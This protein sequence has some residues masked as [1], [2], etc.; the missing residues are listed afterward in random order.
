MAYV[1]IS[2]ST[3][4]GIGTGTVTDTDADTTIGTDTE[5]KMSM[6][7]MASTGRGCRVSRARLCGTGWSG[8][9]LSPMPLP[10]QERGSL[11]G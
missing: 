10:L 9:A 6:P 8:L 3:G 1:G 7:Q 11:G 2:I 5:G 4:T